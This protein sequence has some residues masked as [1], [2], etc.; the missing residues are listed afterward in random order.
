MH[1]NPKAGL[2]LLILLAALHPRPT[3]A[4]D[5]PAPDLV[6]DRPDQTESS[7]VVPP[8]YV[9]IETGITYTDD[10]SASRTLEYPST[11]I[12][13]G[14]VERLELRLGITG[15]V[16]EFEGNETTGF[17]DSEVGIKLYLW[18]EKG[19][20]P[21]AALLAG[22]SVPTDKD[23]FSSDRFDPAF[24]FSFAHTLSDRAS[25]GYNIGV[26]W[27][28]QDTAAAPPSSVHRLS[29][30]QY[31]LVSGIGI[32]DKLS[33]F[34]ELYGDI[35]LSAPG[36]S[37]HS[38]DGGFTYLV[39]PNL[40]LDIAGGFGLTRDAADWFIGTGVSVRFPR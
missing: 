32:T 22:T 33:T 13:A 29:V 26:A 38:F 28:S 1:R 31:T 24:R 30:L 8:G 3:G 15:F 4:Q 7:V 20:R 25:L 18:S 11:L 40:Q 10:G 6:T 27:E 37:A 5:E 16:S 35:P 9:Q 19:A 39:R 23:T 21:E 14:L 17:G 34:V 36:G 2:A 12:R